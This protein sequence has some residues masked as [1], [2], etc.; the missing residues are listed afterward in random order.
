VP[1]TYTDNLRITKQGTNDNPNGWGEITNRQVIELLED[2]IAGVLEV[3]VTGSSDVTLT[4]E[5]GADDQAR[6][7]GIELV[8]TLGANIELILP[9]VNKFY[10]F[11]GAWSGDYTVTAKISGS[12]TS[13][14]INTGDVLYCYTNGTDIY[15]ISQDAL[16]VGN[17]LSDVDSAAAA[18]NNLGLGDLATLDAGTGLAVSGGNLNVTVSSNIVGEIKLWVT[19]TA[20]SGWLS[21]D[22]S[23]VSRTTYA[24]LFAV[25]GTTFGS[26]NGATTFNL[27]DFRGRAPVGIG[28]G[29][30]AEGGGTGTSRSLASKFGA[31]THRL[32]VSQMPSHTHSE[33]GFKYGPAAAKG[34]TEHGAFLTQTGPAGGDQPHNNMSPGLGI[35][36]IIY[37]GV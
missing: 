8:G 24:S 2:A 19:G 15:N 25:M 35:N 32:T 12:S 36:F 17:N 18:R 7:A 21:C 33:I 3:S 20:P 31:E 16:L 1:S 4:T 26:G 27:P 30:T 11:R 28:Q 9:S 5:N 37:T 34:G 13:V 23:A 29:D 10:V 6:Y 14:V 22:G